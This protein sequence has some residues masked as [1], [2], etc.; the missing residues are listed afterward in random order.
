MLGVDKKRKPKQNNDWRLG[1]ISYYFFVFE[2]NL[3][4]LMSAQPSEHRLRQ[5]HHL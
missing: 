4:S 1:N 2:T 3:S 5:D